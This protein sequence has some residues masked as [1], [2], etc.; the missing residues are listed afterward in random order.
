MNIHQAQKA[1]KEQ[2]AEE[3]IEFAESATELRAQGLDPYGVAMRRALQSVDDNLETP[4]NVWKTVFQRKIDLLKAA[5][6]KPNLTER[7]MK[8]VAVA[9]LA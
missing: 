5:A 3:T 6:A 8:N 7:E 2:V 4:T 9:L 1:L